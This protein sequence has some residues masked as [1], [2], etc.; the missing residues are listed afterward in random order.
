VSVAASEVASPQSSLSLALLYFG[1]EAVHPLLLADPLTSWSGRR[2]FHLV[3]L[4]GR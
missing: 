2:A 1:I 4:V 3:Y